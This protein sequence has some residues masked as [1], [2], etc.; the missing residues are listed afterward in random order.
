M[1]SL[2]LTLHSLHTL[3]IRFNLWTMSLAWL[4]WSWLLFLIWSMV[5]YYGVLATVL[6]SGKVE[7]IL[8]GSLDLIP[9]LS[10]KIQIMGRKLD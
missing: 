9:S 10:V 6:V 4:D 7:T 2:V 1:S 3:V 5:I 8:K